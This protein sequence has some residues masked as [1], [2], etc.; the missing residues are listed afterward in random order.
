MS[1]NNRAFRSNPNNIADSC[2]YLD[3]IE[4]MS[5][6]NRAFRSNPNKKSWVLVPGSINVTK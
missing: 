3:W 1:Q 2:P 4:V 6:N 5:Q